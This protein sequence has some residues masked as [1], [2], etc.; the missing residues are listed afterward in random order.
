MADASSTSMAQSMAAFAAMSPEQKREHLDYLRARFESLPPEEQRKIMAAS[1]RQLQYAQAHGIPLIPLGDRKEEESSSDEEA[2]VIKPSECVLSNRNKPQVVTT[3]PVPSRGEHD[4]MAEVEKEKRKRLR[5]KRKPMKPGQWARVR[6]LHFSRG[7]WSAPIRYEKNQWRT[8]AT[9]DEKYGPWQKEISL[10]SY[11]LSRFERLDLKDHALGLLKAIKSRDPDFVAIEG[12]RTAIA[13]LLM[14]D[15]IIKKRYWVNLGSNL[16]QNPTHT[17]KSVITL[18]RIPPIKAESLIFS[19]SKSE[20]IA[21]HFVVNG[22]PLK[23]VAASAP[24]CD[25]DF[26]AECPCDRSF[27]VSHLLSSLPIPPIHRKESSKQAQPDSNNPNTNNTPNSDKKPGTSK[28]PSELVKNYQ[29]KSKS[30]KMPDLI[31]LGDLRCS[32]NGTIS[33]TSGQVT[34]I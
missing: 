20:A 29:L 27:A 4:E 32:C 6:S 21:C 5:M 24:E 7:H 30:V 13:G 16:T 2:T 33:G 15:N 23:I 25:G 34:L 18:S 22:E 1:R 12:A 19:S 9:V 17:T 10:L 28:R 11:D 8:Y 26:D 3:Q 14:N 31:L